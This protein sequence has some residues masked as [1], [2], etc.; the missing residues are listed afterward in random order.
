MENKR[1][2]GSRFEL[3]HIPQGGFRFSFFDACDHL[4]YRS[5]FFASSRQAADAIATVKCGF[6]P[7][8][9][10]RLRS[11]TG[12]GFY[13]TISGP[14]HSLLATST[15]FMS[16]RAREAA[17]ATAFRD[18]STAP[19]FNGATCETAQSANDDEAA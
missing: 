1:L 11:R 9:L 18:A 3:E 16:L 4:V 8:N 12:S 2:A 13:F 10:N 5:G 19:V 17:I 15:M 6:G 7:M 14:A